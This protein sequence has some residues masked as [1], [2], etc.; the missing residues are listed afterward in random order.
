MA[1]LAPRIDVERALDQCLPGLREHLDDHVV[2]DE[3]F[4]DDLSHKIKIGLRR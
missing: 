3:V 1:C 2:R 4:F